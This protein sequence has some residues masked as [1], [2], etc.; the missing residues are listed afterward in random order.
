MERF[1][2]TD[3]AELRIRQRGLSR[4]ELEDAVRDGHERRQINRGDGGWRILGVAGDGHD[5]VVI[6]D[7]PALGQGQTARIISAWRLRVSD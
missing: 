5:F 4:L 6:Y 1:I 2:W 7:F 3:H